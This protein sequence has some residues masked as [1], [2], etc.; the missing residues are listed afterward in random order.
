MRQLSNVMIVSLALAGFAGVSMAEEFEG[1]VH[2]KSTR[3]GKAREYDYLIKG[4]KVRVEIGEGRQQFNVIVD[5]DAK[6]TLLLMPERKMMMEMPRMDE[7]KRPSEQE[8]KLDFTK[9]GKTDTVLGYTCELLNVR[10]EGSETEVCGAKGLG[11]YAGMHRPGMGSS[12]GAPAWTKTLKELGFFPLRVVTKGSD[13]G[14]KLRLEA[15]RIEKKPLDASL[16]VAP[17]DYKKFDRGMGSP[18]KMREDMER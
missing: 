16:F 9:T 14:E 3:E 11:Y 2:F 4:N 5:Q 7:T 8:Q 6:K 13:G 15:T 17:E 1:I 12:D 18:G 10:M